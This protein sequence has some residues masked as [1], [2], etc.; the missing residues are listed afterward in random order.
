MGPAAVNSPVDDVRQAIDR[1][2]HDGQ[3]W[4]GGGRYQS[5]FNAL[6]HEARWASDR[7]VDSGELI[8]PQGSRRLLGATAYL[9]LLDQVGGCF[10]RLTADAG[11]PREPDLMRALRHF[12]QVED[13]AT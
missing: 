5:S 10:I 1:H 9:M 2:L 3:P 4:P 7:D 11:G 6:L 8:D 13:E 12:S